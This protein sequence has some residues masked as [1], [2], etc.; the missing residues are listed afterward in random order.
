MLLKVFKCTR[1]LSSPSAILSLP[2]PAAA[3]QGNTCHPFRS[4]PGFAR[5]IGQQLAA[6]L[7]C[8]LR[9]RGEKVEVWRIF[10]WA[11]AEPVPHL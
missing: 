1:Y 3:I 5:E 2:P 4:A 10:S 9:E 8:H 6:C 7:R 11:E